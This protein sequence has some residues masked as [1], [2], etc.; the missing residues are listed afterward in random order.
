M[1]LTHREMAKITKTGG[2]QWRDKPI[3][4]VKEVTPPVH[5]IGETL[6]HVTSEH[7][8]TLQLIENSQNKIFIGKNPALK[9]TSPKLLQQV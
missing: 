2:K 3:F 7:V 1:G 6:S 8:Q 5:P 4:W 9:A